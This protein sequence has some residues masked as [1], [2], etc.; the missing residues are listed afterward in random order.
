M[1]SY[2]LFFTA[3]IFNEP[4]IN[5]VPIVLDCLFLVAIPLWSICFGWLFVKMD[6]WLNHFPTLG[7]KVF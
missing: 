1:G 2:F 5:F 3:A 7:R 6:N 4:D